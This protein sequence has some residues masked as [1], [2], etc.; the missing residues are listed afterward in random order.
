[1]I[2]ALTLWGYWRSS[3]SYR[4][5]IALGL[6]SLRHDYRP[7]NLKLGEQKSEDYLAVNPHGTVP[8][9]Q[10]G[11]VQMTQSLAILDWLDATY[12]DPAFVPTDAPELCRD[13]YYAVATEIHAPNNLAVL[14]YLR[15]E[16]GADQAAIEAWYATWIA[17]TFAPVEARLA[18]HTWAS[19]DLPFGQ[20]TLFEI[21][22]IPQVYNARRWKTDL[23]AYPLIAK[24]DA[25]CATLEAF[26]R[27]RPENQIDAT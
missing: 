21:V 11:D 25:H 27:A 4:I 14:K 2:D 20:P 7:I 13:L 18:A 26:D 8:L 1:M 12:P 15:T 23:L 24:I 6:K 10:A 9:F 22:L 3:T 5:R 17:K 19:P 16:F